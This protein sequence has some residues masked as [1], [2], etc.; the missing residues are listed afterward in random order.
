MGACRAP[1]HYRELDV[2]FTR[3]TST[4]L[5]TRPGPEA[6]HGDVGLSMRVEGEDEE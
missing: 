6:S 2:E 3:N 5:P 4:K 1:L